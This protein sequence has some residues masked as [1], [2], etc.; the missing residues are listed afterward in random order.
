MIDPSTDTLKSSAPR[1]ATSSP[2]SSDVRRLTE[3]E[4]PPELTAAPLFVGDVSGDASTFARRASRLASA[5]SGS[6]SA[7]LVWSMRFAS[8]AFQLLRARCAGGT[9]DPPRSLSRDKRYSC[10][11]S[12]L[13]FG[14]FAAASPPAPP[15]PEGRGAKSASF[16]SMRPTT[17][18]ISSMDARDGEAADLIGDTSRLGGNC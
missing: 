7:S 16:T 10:S 5:V 9:W 17:D 3:P 14:W 15:A 12:V 8:P 18:A 6:P 1:P 2:T 4:S 13:A 11:S